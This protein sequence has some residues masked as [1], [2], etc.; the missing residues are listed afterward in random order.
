MKSLSDRVLDQIKKFPLKCRDQILLESYNNYK[1]SH[2]NMKQRL[3]NRIYKM[4]EKG[5]YFI[6][7]TFKNEPDEQST[8]KLM[9]TWAPKNCHEYVCNID[10]GNDNNRIHI[11]CVCVPKH[12]L[13]KT[14]KYGAINILKVRNNKNDERK[15]I[16]YITKLLN[17]SLKHQT[18]HIIRSRERRK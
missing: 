12:Q 1:S 13:H 10:Y 18:S 2:Y 3:Y 9:K 5:A 14:W 8:I 6:T 7:L 17:H 11:H 16:L 15:A 4:N